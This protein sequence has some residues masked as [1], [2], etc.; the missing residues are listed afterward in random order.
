MW[1]ITLLLA[2][3][4]HAEYSTVAA[5]IDRLVLNTV[6]ASWGSLCSL[7]ALLSAVARARRYPVSLWF[8]EESFLVLIVVFITE[9]WGEISAVSVLLYL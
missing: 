2:W 1:F 9:G 7:S 4:I 6:G 3:Q 8:W 5:V